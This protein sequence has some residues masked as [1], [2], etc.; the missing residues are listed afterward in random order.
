MRKFSTEPLKKQLNRVFPQYSYVVETSIG[1]NMVQE[2]KRHFARI[3][4]DRFGISF[5]AAEKELYRV[6]SRDRC[7]EG[8]ADRMS[9]FL[10]LHPALLWEEWER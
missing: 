8:I 2:G 5:A 10:G 9:M 1:S 4:A 6:L 7:S 3:Y